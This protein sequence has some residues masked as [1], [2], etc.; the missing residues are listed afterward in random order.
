MYQD[1]SEKQKQNIASWMHYADKNKTLFFV[2]SSVYEH[3]NL[4]YREYAYT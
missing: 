1:F 2:F 4:S 3:I